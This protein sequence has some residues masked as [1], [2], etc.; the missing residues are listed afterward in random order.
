MSPRR[1]R[2]KNLTMIVISTLLLGCSTVLA[3]DD[4]QDEEYGNCA[5]ST[6]LQ[7]NQEKMDYINK[8]RMAKEASESPYGEIFVNTV[9]ARL[10]TGEVMELDTFTVDCIACHDGINAPGREIRYKNDSVNRRIDLNSVL[11]SHPI[12][13][14]YGSY[15]YA[16]PQYKRLEKLDPNMVLVDGK[17]GC[18]T[19]HN[20][21]NK[22]K[23]HLAIDKERS[24]LC[25][26]CHQV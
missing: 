20:P 1:Y 9:Q 24:K 10:R 6:Q 16:S 15:A 7:D 23:N 13:M 5:F 4:Q 26:A 12:G 25:Y 2:N 3:Y 21:L 19:C 8:L 11:G 17:I 22:K 14:D 18:L